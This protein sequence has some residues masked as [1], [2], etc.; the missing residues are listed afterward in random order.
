MYN[1][2]AKRGFRISLKKF[3]SKGIQNNTPHFS[4][5]IFDMN[6]LVKLCNPNI[7]HENEFHVLRK[8]N[9]FL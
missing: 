2:E 4:F 5:A 6:N 9:L 7:V 1:F 3:Q 8:T